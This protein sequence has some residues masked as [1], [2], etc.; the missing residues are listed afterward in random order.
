[1][2]LKYLRFFWCL[3]RD[4]YFDITLANVEEHEN[5]REKDLYKFHRTESYKLNVRKTCCNYE[6]DSK[7]NVKFLE[8]FIVS[9]F[10]C[11]VFL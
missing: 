10:P 5:E 8:K 11:V 7:R 9:G 3:V 6:E 2:Q 1:M 4:K